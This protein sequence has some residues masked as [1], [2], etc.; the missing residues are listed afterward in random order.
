MRVVDVA[1]SQGV[2]VL[3]GAELAAWRGG[4]AALAAGVEGLGVEVPAVDFFPERAAPRPRSTPR[5]GHPRMR[6]VDVA[7]SQGVLV[8]LDAE[9][10]AWRGGGAALAA[11]VEGLGVEGHAVDFFPE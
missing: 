4:G 5:Y 2:L 8:L 3:L 11:G 1:T 7:T 6:V 10:A 9:L